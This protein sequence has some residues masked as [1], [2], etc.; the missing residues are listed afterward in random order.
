MRSHVFALSQ[1]L[2]GQILKLTQ[3][4]FVLL[5]HCL[6]YYAVLKLTNL[7]YSLKA[8]LKWDLL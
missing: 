5:F 7:P 2:I 1:A 4:R 8:T 6:F 3:Q